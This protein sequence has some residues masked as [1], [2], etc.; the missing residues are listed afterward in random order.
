M[1]FVICKTDVGEHEQLLIREAQAG[2][3]DAFAGLIRIHHRSVRSFVARHVG[4]AATTDDIAQ[5]VFL[6]AFRGLGSFRGTG[7]LAPW[8][9]AIAR[10]LVASHLRELSRRNRLHG[11]DLVRAL[12]E[13]KL[14]QIDVDPF[15]LE[16][17]DRTVTALR[18]CITKLPSNHRLII[19][20]FYFEH[21]T[22]E[23]LAEKFGRQAGSIRMMLLRIRKVLRECLHKKLGQEG[24]T[25]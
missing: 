18:D 24:V 14:G 1:E 3:H 8:L 9:F 21:E 17:A 7:S 2:C 13:W 12:A 10:N 15:D 16:D 22:A 19:R 4:E 11:S 23:S 25:L 5:D 6:N 20:Q